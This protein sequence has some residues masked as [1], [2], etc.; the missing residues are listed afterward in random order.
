[1]LRCIAYQDS[2]RG[3]WDRL[4][5]ARGSIFH[6]IA[7]RSILLD[8]FGYQCAYHAVV[9]EQK[10]MRAILPMVVGRNLS[11]KRVGVS[12]PFIN[13]ADICAVDEEAGAFAIQ[14]ATA[15]QEKQQLKSV[16]LR[17]KEQKIESPDWQSYSQNCTFVLPLP[18]DETAT[19]AQATASCRNHVRKT[20]KNNWFEAS[21]DADRLPD[22]YKVYVR[23]MK[24]LGSPAPSIRFF[25]NFFRYL[26]EQTSLLTVLDQQTKKVVGGMLLV[27]DEAQ[28]T[29]YYP[30]GANLVEYNSRYLNN[31]M[32]WEA[33]K[34]GLK[35]EMKTLDLGRSPI[36]S[37]TYHYKLQWGAQPKPLQ[38]LF[39]GN[40][41]E[42]AGPPD[43][44]RLH[45][46]I[47]R[48]KVLP[49]LITGPVG[50]KIIQYVMP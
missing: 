26:P 48:W 45:L 34:F 35:K 8:S 15:I 2:L 21:F 3:E 28:A 11:G 42:A 18:A 40:R 46:F 39:Y 19:L 38:Y 32:Y 5:S 37:G 25:Q 49:D 12:L 44:E 20:Y 9:D 47:E 6:T 33:V 16:E 23:R 10:T 50:K 14:S 1:M 22:F 13:F 17:L 43:K 27:A 30:Y 29:L 7:F 24:Q 41:G 31:F 36:G 4:A